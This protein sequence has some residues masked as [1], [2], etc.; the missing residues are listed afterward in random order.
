MAKT[1]SRPPRK[2]PVT[3]RPAPKRRTKKQIEQDKQRRVAIMGISAV[4]ILIAVVV[5]SMIAFKGSNSDVATEQKPK[6]EVAKVEKTETVKDTTPETVED[7]DIIAQVKVILYDHEIE[8]GAVEERISTATNGYKNVYINVEKYNEEDYIEVLSAV[9]AYLSKN[10]FD[11]VLNNK[12][13]IASN[14]TLEI[15]LVFDP[16]A[17]AV[18]ETAKIPVITEPP[19]NPAPVKEAKMPTPPA[20]SPVVLKMAIVLDDGGNSVQLAER[21]VKINYP[22]TIAILPNLEHSRE[23]AIISNAYKKTVLLHFP[24]QPKAYPDVDPGEG[25]ILLSMPEMLIEGVVRQNMESL[26]VPIDGFNNHMGSAATEDSSKM[27]QVMKLMKQ[28]TNVFLDSR[29]T[30]QTVAFDECVKAGMSC[31]MNRKFLDNENSVPYIVGKLYE[32]VEYAKN[33]GG[34]VVTIGHVREKTLEALEYAL[35]ILEDLNVAIV[36]VTDLA[37]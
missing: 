14:D 13:L 37:R 20:K 26:G 6:Q 7:V 30:A 8:R 36:P 18:K 10:E 11:T 35:P 22:L 34:E 4:A 32:A 25:A 19:T 16:N 23:V 29:T 3:K 5:I 1:T 27:S 24:M 33:N 28:H 12:M 9:N 21:F 17:N 2:T 31:A 15:Q